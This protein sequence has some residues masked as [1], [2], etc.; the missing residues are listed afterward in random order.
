[1]TA[2]NGICVAI[3]TRH[4]LEF[5]YNDE[6]RIV[7]P[8]CHGTNTRG[9]EALRAVQIGGG[10]KSGGVGFGKLWL[11]DKISNLRVSPTPF[12]PDDPDYNPD[13]SAMTSIH[14]RI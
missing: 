11:V 14:C 3:K 12:T 5:D 1:M 9:L 8:Y 10:T 13:D 4:L 6:H 2:S 7:A